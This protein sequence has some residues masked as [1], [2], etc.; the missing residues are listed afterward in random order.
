[1]ESLIE[2]RIV[3]YV[4]P[5]GR[6]AGQVRPAIVVRVWRGADGKAQEN[7]ICQLCVFVDGNNDVFSEKAVQPPQ[8]TQ[9]HSS[10]TYDESGALG[11]WHWPPRA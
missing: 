5:D 6:S 10:I 7:G 9:W 4:L 8:M 11:T 3:H 1:M 2:G